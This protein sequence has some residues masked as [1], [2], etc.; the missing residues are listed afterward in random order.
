M[1]APRIFALLALLATVGT[2][3]A[4][5]VIEQPERSF[6][7]GLA[8]LTLPSSATG[9]VSFKTCESCAYS[10]HVLQSSTRFAVN[11]QAVPFAEF[12]RIAEELR[13][14]RTT[15]E[16]TFAGVFIDADTGRVTRITLRHRNR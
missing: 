5:R 7:L 15:R 8:Q 16:T 13:A 4:T 14:N 12:T 1:K 2:A 9:G 10:T 11:G 3:N 6:E